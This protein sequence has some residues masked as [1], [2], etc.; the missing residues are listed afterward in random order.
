MHAWR[1]AD[2]GCEFSVT[3]CLSVCV[4]EHVGFVIL[5]E[6]PLLANQS[7]LFGLSFFEHSKKGEGEETRN[8]IVQK[9]KKKITAEVGKKKKKKK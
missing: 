1:K 6:N 5:M 2:S 4:S 8:R 7:R 3:V 9:W